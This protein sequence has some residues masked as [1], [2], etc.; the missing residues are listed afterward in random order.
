MFS[1]LHKNSFQKIVCSIGWRPFPIYI[2]LPT[3]KKV[4]PKTINPEEDVWISTF[5]CCAVY[6]KILARSS[7]VFSSSE[8]EMSVNIFGR[9][10][11]ITT[12]HFNSEPRALTDSNN[13]Y[14]SLTISILWVTVLEV[15]MM[16]YMIFS[17]NSIGRCKAT[18]PLLPTKSRCA[19]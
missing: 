12:T 2:G 10:P 9:V 13:S 6:W 17:I 7:I 16:G 11:S 19:T 5:T 4:S 15:K 14:P 1:F 18:I 8:S 3:C